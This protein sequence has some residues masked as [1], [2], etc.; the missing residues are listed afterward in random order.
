MR[1]LKVKIG[2]YAVERL[3]TMAIVR[4]NSLKLVD[5]CFILMVGR[6]VEKLRG[7][8]DVSRRTE[9]STYQYLSGDET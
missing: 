9:T 4:G 3:N 6:A 7:C 2:N 8:E 5:I 1:I